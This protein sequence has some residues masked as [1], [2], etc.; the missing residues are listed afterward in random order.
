MAAIS[1]N[2]D[3]NYI[4]L[5]LQNGSSQ[6]VIARCSREDLVTFT[7]AYNPAAGTTA[8]VVMAPSD[9]DQ[10]LF[11]GYF[12]SGVQVVRHNIGAA[13][14]TNISPAGLGTAVVNCLAVNPSDANEIYIT[15]NTA[16]DVM[17]T[18]DGGATWETLNSALGFDP[19]A[20]RVFWG[21]EYEDDILLIGGK[22]ASVQ[23]LFSPNAGTYTSN[24]A[25]ASLGATANIVGI[26]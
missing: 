26:E 16:Q 21:G 2:S 5:A 11:Y 6:P 14:N 25:G 23:L 12:G 19:T 13:T 3:G 22:P 24:I 1:T 10:M 8:N 9:P 17:Y 7:Y 18:V 4:F 20:L 15:V